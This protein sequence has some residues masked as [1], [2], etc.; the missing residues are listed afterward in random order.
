MCYSNCWAIKKT[1]QNEEKVMKTKWKLGIAGVG[2]VS[3]IGIA[4]GTVYA[5]G[6]WE[7]YSFPPGGNSSAAGVEIH[8]D[9]ANLEATDYVTMNDRPNA[10]GQGWLVF[11]GGFLQPDSDLIYMLPGNAADTTDDQLSIF[12][13]NL[14]VQSS[15]DVLIRSLDGDVLVQL[16]N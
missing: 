10:Q 11:D 5:A 4:I 3:V 13:D 9:F 15:N 12:S 7:I 14:L 16:G 1:D 8:A 2:V 6:D